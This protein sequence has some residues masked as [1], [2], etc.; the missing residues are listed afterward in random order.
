MV[1]SKI[2]NLKISH[3]LMLLFLV[4]SIVVNAS[5]TMIL[6]SLASSQIM[7]DM[8]RRL[9]DVVSISA[10]IIDGDL[11]ATLVDPA[12]QNSEVYL[13]VKKRLQQILDAS[14][15]IH[16][17]YTMRNSGKDWHEKSGLTVDAD[18]SL[19]S[20]SRI[21]FVVD[22][23]TDPTQMANLGDI[24]H[25]ASPLLKKT[26][27]GMDKPVIE[28]Q[29]YSDK[30]GTWLSGYAPF[31]DH[32]GKRSG[33]LGIDI[34]AKTVEVYRNKILFKALLIFFM[35][36][37][38]VLVAGLWL[39]RRIGRPMMTMQKGARQMAEGDLDL[40]LEIPNGL[41]MSILAQTLNQM[42]ENLQDEQQNLQCMALKY[43]GIFQ[44]ATE[45]I[46]QVSSEGHLL[47]ANNAM[48]RM[49]GYTGLDELPQFFDKRMPHVFAQSEDQEK[50]V[51]G[52]LENGRVDTVPVQIKRR[53][54]SIFWAEL[55]AHMVDSEKGEKITE[56]TMQDITQRLERERA[57]REKEAAIASSQSKSEFLANMS[58]EIRTP[59]NA[60]MGLTDLVMR[61]ELSDKQQQYLKKI[62]IASK[63]LL[64]VIN[65][66]LDFS[67][68]EA[69]RLELEHANF[70]IFDLM[71]N[72]SEM[73]AFKAEEKG[74]EFLVS[75]DENTPVA[76]IGDSV[77]L[78]QVLINLIGNA[79]KFTE[80]GEIVVQVKTLLASEADLIEDNSRA[81]ADSAS[82]VNKKLVLE[83]SVRDTGIGIPADRLEVLFD[84]FT[85]ADS[86]T[87]RK[88]GG[89]GLGL[90]ICR[91]LAQLMGGDISVTS[92]PGKGSCFSFTV[93]LESQ[94]QKDQFVLHPPR[95]LRGLNVLVVD[96][97]STAREIMTTII[98][99]FEMK[100]VTASSGAQALKILSADDQAFDLVL[101]D[102]KMPCM[103]GLEAARKIKLD[104]EL[105]K[106]PIVCMVSAHAREDLFS[107]A[108]KNFIDA[109][110][111]KPVNQSFLF[112]AIM[113]LFGR[114]DAVLAKTSV[115][116]PSKDRRDNR[117]KGKKILLVED[118]EINREIALEWLHSAGL[119]TD[120]VVNGRKALDY[121]A[122][123]E[124]PD[125]V[126]MDI[127]MPEMDGLEATSHLRKESRFNKL[128]V[129]A[130]TA[131]ALKGDREKCLD[132]GMDDY[133]TKPIDPDKL[134]STLAKWIG[135]LSKEENEIL[136]VGETVPFEAVHAPPLDTGNRNGTL[137]GDDESLELPGIDVKSGFFR[138]NNNQKLYEKLLRTFVL[139]FT[140]I[141]VEIA[142]CLT[143]ND[144]ET[145][146]RTVH[147]IKGVA[148]NLGAEHLSAAAADVESSLSTQEETVPGNTWENFC[149]QLNQVISGIEACFQ[150]E[151]TGK[152][153]DKQDLKVDNEFRVDKVFLREQLGQIKALLDDDLN[154]ARQQ[155]E[156]VG[157][158]LQLVVEESLYRGLMAHIDGFEIDEASEIIAEISNKL[159]NE[160]QE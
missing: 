21:M 11:H 58:H 151:E 69:G 145:A 134:F 88:Y 47:T 106:I 120:Y 31:Y 146:R 113:E 12:Q 33:V 138:A 72:V 78:G 91:Q 62:I 133:I 60:V 27:S 28:S 65:D 7:Q 38:I 127:Q 143:G 109:F 100:A 122:D 114:H 129:I 73:F 98:Q 54:G 82:E 30:W 15:D 26:F 77:R 126:L 51:A 55:N 64:A 137:S 63:S 41:E 141:E 132:A 9:H 19:Q 115:A 24:Y 159:I 37:P 18:R 20:Q 136:P 95:D 74:L 124:L 59:L 36:L 35:T 89:T 94:P 76:L 48:L 22:A 108:D 8:Q 42:A 4:L 123:N 112:D 68:I 99:S 97:N 86:S 101:M 93:I 155:L 96:D 52:L 75:I 144:R 142:R 139:D 10:S 32:Q 71:S 1:T 49:L 3:Y 149:W 90:A 160:V 5:I 111:H 44:N 156:V 70:S 103:N 80:N 158:D 56:G 153:I 118:N 25:D 40:R 61:T 105:E 87:T 57:E 104:L 79:L 135:N 125:A 102:W 81:T 128:P 45:G 148:A 121:L 150:T 116:S 29:L 92:E 67:K 13:V 130:M 84:S 39:G 16:F 14:S 131:H 53:D 119:E 147:S 46:F 83:F 50:I 152:N 6:Y 107:H 23:E 140:G 2:R 66:I 85:Q 157:P 154:A 117:L 34:S 17:I 43:E 110:L